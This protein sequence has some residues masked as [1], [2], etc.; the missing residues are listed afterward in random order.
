MASLI[1]SKGKQKAFKSCSL[2]SSGRLLELVG[3]NKSRWMAIR[4]LVNDRTR[5]IEDLTLQYVTVTTCG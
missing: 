5:G 1:G 3:N 4:S 2:K